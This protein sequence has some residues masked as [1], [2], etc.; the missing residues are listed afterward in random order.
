MGRAGSDQQVKS[1]SCAI[2]ALSSVRSTEPSN[3]DKDQLRTPAASSWFYPNKDT[4]R[5]GLQESVPSPPQQGN[6]RDERSSEPADQ[7]VTSQV[8][9]AS[10]SKREKSQHQIAGKIKIIKRL[11]NINNPQQQK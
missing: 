5:R 3:T 7:S 11:K 2:S 10:G 6:S 1:E 8:Y 4:T 9:T